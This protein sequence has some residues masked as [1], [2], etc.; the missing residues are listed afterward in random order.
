MNIN[1]TPLAWLVY[2][3]I[4]GGILTVLYNGI[5]LFMLRRDR[6]RETVL[7][8]SDN[9]SPSGATAQL[10]PLLQSPPETV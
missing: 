9:P 7:S 6:L 5:L 3:S 1:G 2:F 4:G 8:V 10:V